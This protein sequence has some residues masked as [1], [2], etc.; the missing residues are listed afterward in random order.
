M[1]KSGKRR[2]EKGCQAE[3]WN[4]DAIDIVYK[5]PKLINED[6]KIKVLKKRVETFFEFDR[7]IS[8]NKNIKKFLS[9]ATQKVI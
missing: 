2:K 5:S 3:F 1:A 9:M 4:I 6:G 7:D 8:R